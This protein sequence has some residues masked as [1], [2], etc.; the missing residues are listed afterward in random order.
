MA[1]LKLILRI[2]LNFYN[3]VLCYLSNASNVKIIV[4]IVLMIMI[5]MVTMSMIKTG[6]VKGYGGGRLVI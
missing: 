5:M 1:T 2:I 4:K 6:G 3:K